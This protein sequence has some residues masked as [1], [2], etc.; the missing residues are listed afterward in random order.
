MTGRNAGSKGLFGQLRIINSR[1]PNS[2]ARVMAGDRLPC[3]RLLA[4]PLRCSAA[5][6]AGALRAPRRVPLGGDA[7]GRT[8][9]A[10]AVGRAVAAGRGVRGVG[11]GWTHAHSP[12]LPHPSRRPPRGRGRPTRR[13]PRPCHQQARRRSRGAPVGSSCGSGSATAGADAVEPTRSASR[14]DPVRSGNAGLSA[15]DRRGGLCCPCR[16]PRG[17]EIG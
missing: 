3:R 11:A 15:L 13:R 17:G 8:S 9:V 2:S 5:C 6:Y 1:R 4:C 10:G 14:S 12:H 7:V 16:H